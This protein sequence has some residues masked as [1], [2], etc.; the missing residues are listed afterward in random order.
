MSI[1][2]VAHAVAVHRRR[3]GLDRA[4]SPYEQLQSRSP[5]PTM[6]TMAGDSKQSGP[7]QDDRPP[8]RG[9][10]CWLLPVSVRSAVLDNAGNSD[11]S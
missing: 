3:S 11:H 4:S 7:R 9:L 10:L 1:G 5:S 6:W 8:S 2:S